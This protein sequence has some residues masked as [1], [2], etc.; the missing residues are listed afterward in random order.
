[1]QDNPN[2]KYNLT[3]KNI[4]HYSRNFGSKGSILKG[5]DKSPTLTSAMGSGGG[6]VPAIDEKYYLRNNDIEDVK[7]STYQGDKIHNING[8]MSCLA[9]QGGNKL[10]GIGIEVDEKYY[11]S[12]KAIAKIK[13][14][15]NKSLSNDLSN[16]IHAGYYK[17]GGRDQQY[18]SHSL[19]PRSSTTGKGGTGHLSKSDGTSYCLDTGNAQAIE[20]I[21]DY[22]NDE[23]LR[24]RKDK[25][26]PCLAS[27]KHSSTD[28]S[29][30]PPII[31]NNKIRRLTPIE[32][33][34]LQGFPDNFT[35]GVSDTQRYKQMG[36]T[37]T[38]NV[39][40]AILKNLKIN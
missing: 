10:R 40:Q 4:K 20:W 23:G 5:E 22:R 2:S 37:I 16:C 11:L 19:H 1:L 32:C 3:K 21:A 38:V 12:D 26:S 7:K 39:I 27:R 6:N 8:N 14:H 15:K 31:K 24:I 33:E 25:L 13:R 18:I 30:M 34:R 17:Q 36:N 28:I 9:A 35:E 29:T